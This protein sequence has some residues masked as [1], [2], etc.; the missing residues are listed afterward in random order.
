LKEVVIDRKVITSITT[1][2]LME[3]LKYGVDKLTER[4]VI[5]LEG[6]KIKSQGE[7]IVEIYLEEEKVKVMAQVIESK[8]KTLLLG[9]D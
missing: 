5:T 1:K 4:N 2:G 6:E 3:K 8:D 9:N 7:I